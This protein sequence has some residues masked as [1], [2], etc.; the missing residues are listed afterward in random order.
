LEGS[1][2]SVLRKFWVQEENGIGSNIDSDVDLHCWRE[3]RSVAI[4]SWWIG[5]LNNIK[6]RNFIHKKGVITKEK[7]IAPKADLIGWYIDANT[8]TTATVAAII[9]GTVVTGGAIVV[10]G[11]VVGVPTVVSIVVFVRWLSAQETPRRRVLL[12]RLIVILLFRGV[13]PFLGHVVIVIFIFQFPVE[14]ELEVLTV[15]QGLVVLWP[16]PEVS[17][18]CVSV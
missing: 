9:S 11:S 5:F 12:G 3:S 15:G 8:T 18:L 6:K 4:G 14:E 7:P 2:G 10:V 17:L 16:D 1:V 13:V